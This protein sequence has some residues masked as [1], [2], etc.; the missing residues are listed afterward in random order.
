MCSLVG[1]VERLENV[2][3]EQRVA[4]VVQLDLHHVEVI[5][6]ARRRKFRQSC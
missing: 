1:I 6:Q 2:G 3:V 5:V 4:D